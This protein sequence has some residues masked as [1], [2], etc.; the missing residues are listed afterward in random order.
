MS[1][2]RK[3][4]FRAG[5]GSLGIGDVTAPSMPRLCPFGQL[6]RAPLACLRWHEC[7]HADPAAAAFRELIVEAL[8][9]QTAPLA[10]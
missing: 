5:G 2:M 3:A 1:A 8:G 4:W 9:A 10:G 7:S 6:G